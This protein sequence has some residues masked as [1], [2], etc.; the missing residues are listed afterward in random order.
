MGKLKQQLHTCQ[1]TIPQ[2]T[3]DAKDRETLVT[4][5]KDLVVLQTDTWKLFKEWVC[6][7][8]RD[9]PNGLRDVQLIYPALRER[10]INW[11][12]NLNNLKNNLY[13]RCFVSSALENISPAQFRGLKSTF[14]DCERVLIQI[15]NSRESKTNVNEARSAIIVA[16]VEA[17]VLEI[18]SKR[19]AEKELILLE[20][21]A[22]SLIPI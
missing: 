17:L 3:L 6:K 20:N 15:A 4:A 2:V 13:D 7:R 12:A 10:K 5:G 21:L 1:S 19:R 9:V 11:E 14:D 8:L 22:V 16:D 18:T